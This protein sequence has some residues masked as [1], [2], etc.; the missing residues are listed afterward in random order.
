ML[1]TT[2]LLEK[3]GFKQT[4][5]QKKLFLRES[6]GVLISFFGQDNVRVSFPW[7]PISGSVI[8]F[9]TPTEDFKGICIFLRVFGKTPLHD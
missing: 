2:E 1:V 5:S 6:D 3:N 4:S 8:T 7:G 9:E